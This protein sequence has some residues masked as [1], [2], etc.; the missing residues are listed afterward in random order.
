M[1]IG[2]VSEFYYPWPG[3]ISEHICNLARELRSR[4]HDVRILTGRF[5]NRLARMQSRFPSLNV[6]TSH[7]ATPAP[8][9]D[10]VIRF[11]RSLA[12]PYN[13]GVTAVTVG[14]RLSHRLRGVLEREQFDVLHVHD[15]VAPMLPLMAVSMAK[16]PVVGTLHAYHQ[17]ENKLLRLFQRPLRTRMAKLAARIAVSRCAR[18]AFEKYFDNL[19]YRVVPNGVELERFRGNGNQLATRYGPDRQN[20][21]YVGQFVKKKGFG[22]LLDAFEI[23]TRTRDDVR[24][25]AVG[26]GP[27]ERRYRQ[28]P[29]PHVHFLGHHR[30][31]SLASVYEVADLFV[32]PSVGFESFGITLLEAMAAGL[33][34]VASDITGFRNVVNGR[35]GDALVQ[36]P[37]IGASPF[38]KAWQDVGAFDLEE[39]QIRAVELEEAS[40]LVTVAKGEP[41]AYRN[42]C[43]HLGMPLD[44]GSVADG[45]LTCPYHGFQ[46]VLASGECLTAPS[47]QL[48]SYP[49]RVQDGRI[50]VQVTS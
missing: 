9:E 39:H 27:N 41:R 48:P 42:A 44:A 46:F 40:V 25:L 43:A 45:V 32:A 38:A 7:L 2:I 29:A 50:L 34:I 5:D 8:D 26:D 30:G 12:F 23:V 36:L 37:G 20:V 14:S 22:V 15:P 35:R 1:K 18:D 6:G 19:D 24:L 13:G 31:K 17:N 11:G 21:L 28:H 33:P 10:Q 4:G 3:G 16:C 47:V 49:T